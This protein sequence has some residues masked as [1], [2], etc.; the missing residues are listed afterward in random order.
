MNGPR[1]RIEYG[2]TALDELDRITPKLRIQILR[3]IQRLERGLHGNIKR[4][5]AGEA[6]YR[7][8]IGD[9]RAL[10]D[11]ERDIIVIRRVGHRREI[12]D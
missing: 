8:R 9:Y 5:R 3:K 1:F 11:V 10:F 2:A 12:Y 7:L 6:A 4:L